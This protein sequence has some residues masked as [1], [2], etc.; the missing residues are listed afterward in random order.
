MDAAPD[1][2]LPFRKSFW[3]FSIGLQ[4]SNVKYH[5]PNTVPIDSIFLSKAVNTLESYIRR[6]M[7]RKSFRAVPFGV[8]NLFSKHHLPYGI[9]DIKNPHSSVLSLQELHLDNQS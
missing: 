8:Y 7:F 6:L 5:G 9:M 4:I 1:S 3:I 2:D